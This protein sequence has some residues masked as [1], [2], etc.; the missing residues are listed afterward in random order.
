MSWVCSLGASSLLASYKA[1]GF[2]YLVSSTS[3]SRSQQIQSCA[4][5]GDVDERWF[6][7]QNSHISFTEGRTR[8]SCASLWHAAQAALHVW[9]SRERVRKVETSF[10][11]YINKSV[12]FLLHKNKIIFYDFFVNLIFNVFISYNCHTSYKTK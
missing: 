8:F 2:W 6:P 10:N 3:T 5:V 7:V 9:L 1:F 11:S 4:P 12:I